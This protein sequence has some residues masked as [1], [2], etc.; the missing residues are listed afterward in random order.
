MIAL[1]LT[2]ETSKPEPKATFKVRGQWAV[3]W[4]STSNI[5]HIKLLKEH[6]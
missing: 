6:S 5:I 2:D 3:S 4:F 1:H